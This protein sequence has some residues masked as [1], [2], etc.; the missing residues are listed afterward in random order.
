[1]TSPAHKTA[2]QNHTISWFVFPSDFNGK[3]KDWESSFHYYGARYYWSEV[4]TGWLSVD[5]MMDKYPSISPYAYCHWNPIKLVDPNGMDTLFSFATNT[6]DANYNSDNKEILTWMRTEGDVSGMA[7][8]SMH[9]TAKR[10]YVAI[11]DGIEDRGCTAE[12]WATLIKKSNLPDY[13]KN[14]EENNPTIFL[15]YSCNTGNGE[16]SFGQQLS[17][18]LK[19]ITIAP[20][21]KIVIN[22]STHSLTNAVG[23]DD[24]TPQSW[25]VFHQGRKVTSFI[26][27]PKEWIN[28]MGGVEKAAG[29]IVEMDR[30]TKNMVD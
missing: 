11:A 19:N 25:N 21:G 2:H 9:G 30:N 23:K 3:E 7:T 16:N 8:L 18:E 20:E 29:K 22:N 24:L 1:M 6:T 12:E 28:N 5:P 10:G 26:G 4:L 14:Q 13:K 17:S 27:S 15:L